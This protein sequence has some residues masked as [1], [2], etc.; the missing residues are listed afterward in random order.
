MVVDRIQRRNNSMLQK[1][2]FELNHTQVFDPS[3]N[4]W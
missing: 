1:A 4:S 2:A 3:W